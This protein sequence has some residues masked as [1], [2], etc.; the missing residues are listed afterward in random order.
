TPV[1]VT[2]GA[3]WKAVSSLHLFR[4]GKSSAARVGH[5]APYQRPTRRLEF[6]RDVPLAPVDVASFDRWRLPAPAPFAHAA[7][8]NYI[9]ALVREDL[10]EIQVLPGLGARHDEEQVC[11]DRLR[12]TPAADFLRPAI[13]SERKRRA[14][15]N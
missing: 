1:R 14:A 8:K 15:R 10:L 3:R 2:R 9:P 6:P 7:V 12:R 4:I 5:R 13:H 11:H